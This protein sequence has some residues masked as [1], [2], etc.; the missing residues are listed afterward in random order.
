MFLSYRWYYHCGVSQLTTGFI[1][2]NKAR[3]R[4]RRNPDKRF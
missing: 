3:I 2:I 1:P 4:A